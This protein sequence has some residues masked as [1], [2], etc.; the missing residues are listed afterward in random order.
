MPWL[1][2]NQTRLTGDSALPTPVFAD[3]VQ[4]ASMP[5]HPGASATSAPPV[6]CL[7]GRYIYRPSDH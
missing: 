3:D 2:V 5:G 7:P 6:R 4:R 1:T